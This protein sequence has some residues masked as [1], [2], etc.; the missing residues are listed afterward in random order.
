[1]EQ[2]GTGSEFAA[3]EEISIRFN[4]REL[5]WDVSM[6]L[7]RDNGSYFK[8]TD[9]YKTL[10]QALEYVQTLCKPKEDLITGNGPVGSA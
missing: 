4:M 6:L 5:T 7:L 3:V 2:G 1:M 9:Q 8:L 10:T